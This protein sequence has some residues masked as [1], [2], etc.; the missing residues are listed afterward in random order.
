MKIPPLPP[1]TITVLDSKTKVATRSFKTKVEAWMIPVAGKLVRGMMPLKVVAGY[2]G[3][4]DATLRQWRTLG[5]DPGC[6]DPLLVDFALEI[7]K[8]RGE[9]TESAIGMM[10]AH[11]MQ[12]HRALE[13]LLKACDAEVWA[14]KSTVKLEGE[15]S[16]RP[17]IDLSNLTQEELDQYEA[18]H[19]KALPKG[20]T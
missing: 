9:M 13:T 11:A 14:P 7:A 15:I 12:D 3:V 1:G 17:S 10:K 8:A 5:E 19:A 6:A 20:P 4:S 16:V 2:L 18:L